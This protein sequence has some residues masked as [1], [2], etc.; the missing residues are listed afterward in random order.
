MFSPNSYRI[1]CI[2]FLTMNAIKYNKGIKAVYRLIENPKTKKLALI[3]ARAKEEISTNSACN[4][5]K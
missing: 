3:A 5:Q 2:Y 1:N 4:I